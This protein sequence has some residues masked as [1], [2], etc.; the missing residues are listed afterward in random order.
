MQRKFIWIFQTLMRG[1]NVCLQIINQMEQGMNVGRSINIAMAQKDM[2]RPDLARLLG[3]TPPSV[4]A[5]IDRDN[6]TT[7]TLRKLADIFGM[8]VS[9]FIALGEE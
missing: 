3:V 1:V 6:T 2:R 5:I 4:K 8:S 7:D 9:E